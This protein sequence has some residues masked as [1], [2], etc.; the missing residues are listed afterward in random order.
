MK[1][2]AVAAAAAVFASGV[3]AHDNHRRAH[4][5]GLFDK[6]TRPDTAEICVP[7]CTTIYSTI[8]GEPALYTPPPPSKPLVTLWP[9]DG[10]VLP[11]PVPHVCPT[12]GTYSFPAT[13][14]IVEE[15]TTVCAASTTKVPRGTHT[16]GGVTTIVDKATTVTC[17][18][19]AEKTNNGVV[20]NVVELTTYVCPS[21]GTYTIGPVTKTVTEEVK[22]VIVPVVTTICPG[23][24][25]APAVVTVVETATV[26]FCPFE[27]P[28]PRPEHPAPPAPKPEQPAPP[29]QPSQPTTPQRPGPPGLGG[30]GGKWAMTYT[31][32]AVGRCKTASEVD[33]EVAEIARAGFKTMRIYSTDCETL[34]NVGSAAK[35]HG[36]R[37]IS[38]IFIDSKGCKNS[39]PSVPAQ[40]EALKGWNH[41][42][43]V[44]LVVVGNEALFSSHCTPSE[45][46]SLIRQTRTELASC[47]YTGPFTTTDT[48]N[49]WQGPGVE[50]LCSEIDVV[51]L[52]AH[53]YFN[54]A[55]RPSQAG[56]FVKGQLSIVEKICGK[57]GY[58]LETGWPNAGKCIGEACGGPSEQ[59][60]AIKSI[61]D[62]IGDKCVFFSLHDDKWKQETD[63]QCEQHW[64]MGQLFG[65]VF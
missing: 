41:W 30:S 22:T 46:V 26:V 20:T 57:P 23:T 54:A 15:T 62:T 38:G 3:A 47:G 39:N 16:L 37:L 2:V 63:C 64:G 14:V 25:S 51:G 8:T 65:S 42:N 27:T 40:L 34:P 31:P 18:Y 28:A 12:P 24:Y 59:A 48:T 1:G 5:A 19:A 32:Y 45:L 50:A 11:T 60:E 7:Q 36:L 55:T 21:A 6:R 52:N 9:T 4:R 29:T 53:A 13:T 43:L 33:A 17:P 35:K 44:D 56:P 10:P 49:G 61:K 58:I